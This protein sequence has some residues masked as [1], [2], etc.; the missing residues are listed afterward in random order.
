M[1]VINRVLNDIEQRKNA[2]DK[3]DESSFDPVKIN[4]PLRSRWLSGLLILA[5][6]SLTV[7]LTWLY[8]F[9]NRLSVHADIEKTEP[10]AI[11]AVPIAQQALITPEVQKVVTTESMVPSIVIT[12][13]PVENAKK[14]SSKIEEALV[15]KADMKSSTLKQQQLSIEKVESQV[16]EQVSVKALTNQRKVTEKKLEPS[17]IITPIK[18]SNS[19]LSQLKFSQGLKAYKEGRIAQAQKAWEEALQAEPALHDARI[20]LA[21]SYYGANETTRALTLLLQSTSR[22]PAY[23]GYS[24]L[25]AQIYYQLDNPHQALAVL[26]AP[27][28]KETIAVENT[29]LAG[30]IAQQLQQWPAAMNNYQALV[31]KQANNPQWLLGLAIAQDAQNMSALALSHYSHLLTLPGL[32]SAVLDYVKQ[33]AQVLREELVQRGNNG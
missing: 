29:L 15:I 5:L 31:N 25:A 20:Q 13:S 7:V 26:D 30:S 10:Q 9:D 1:S 3:N 32:E 2:P 8:F 14:K 11:K 33:R 27:Y 18:M 19:E 23:S 6:L 12:K 24:L 21:A 17:L 16:I 22:F 28:K 4:E